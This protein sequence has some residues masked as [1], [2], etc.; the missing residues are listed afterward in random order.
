MMRKIMKATREI[1]L[2]AGTIRYRDVGPMQAPV[3]LFVHGLLVNGSLWRKVIPLLSKHYRCIAPDWPLGSHTVPMNHEADV[4]PEGVARIVSDFI[5]E[6]GLRDVT[7]IGNDSGGAITQLVA[8]RHGKHIAC[9]VLTTCDAFEVF[10]PKLFNYLKYVTYVPGLMKM[11]AASMMLIPALRRLPIS[12]G[13][14][15][16]RPIPNEVLEQWIRPGLESADIRRDVSKFI[17]GLSP[18][19]TMQVAREL[20]LVDKP[21]L[22]AWTPEDQSFPV[23][24]AYR[25]KE[26]VLRDARLELI[27]DSLV[28]VAEDQPDRLAVALRRFVSETDRRAD[29]AAATG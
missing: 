15:T 10:P 25:L 16:K 11:L 24:L 28:F 4:S 1:T 17:R 18:A 13:L 7:L 8:A 27:E 21:F 22:L 9:V 23:S 5:E 6:L 3:L 2:D 26:N 12:Y 29:V 14:L 19:I 20:P